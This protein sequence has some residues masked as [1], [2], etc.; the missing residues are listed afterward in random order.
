MS[1]ALESHDHCSDTPA[2]ELHFGLPERK[3]L[4]A[5][6]MLSARL[7]LQPISKIGSEIEWKSEGQRFASHR[8]NAG[9]AQ[10]LAGGAGE[11]GMPV[12]KVLLQIFTFFRN[13]SF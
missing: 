8:F 3:D 7:N 4:Q 11:G 13:P 1:S 5:S 9:G 12:Q 2:V 6:V 10:R